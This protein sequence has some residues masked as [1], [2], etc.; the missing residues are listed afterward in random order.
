MK[1]IA[2]KPHKVDCFAYNKGKCNVL[3]ELVCS[4]KD[5]CSFYANKADVNLGAIERSI[6]NY[7]MN[8]SNK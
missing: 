3:K 8:D 1:P 5:K 2:N 7:S 4:Y 6:N